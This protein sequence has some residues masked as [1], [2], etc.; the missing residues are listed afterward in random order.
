MLIIKF[1]VQ[2]SPTYDLDSLKKGEVVGDGTKLDLPSYDLDSL[3]KGE[4]VGDGTKLDLPSYDLDSLKK[5]EVVDEG[6]KLYKLAI[7]QG[8]FYI[9]FAGCHRTEYIVAIRYG[10]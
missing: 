3:K 10:L 6:T 7:S 2:N 1:K 8:A 4:V 9:V 5:G